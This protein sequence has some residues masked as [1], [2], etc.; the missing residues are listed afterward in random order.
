ME[1]IRQPWCTIDI[2]IPADRICAVFFKCIKRIHC[3][4]LRLT[5]LLTVFILY[6]SKDDNIL[7]RR[8]VKEQCR[9][10]HQRIEPSTGLVYCL[11]NKLSRE[12]FFEKILILK[13][14]MVLCKRHCS[15]IK[16]AVDHFR[17]A[18]HCLTTVRTGKCNGINIWAVKL[19][20]GI[21][22]ITTALSQLCTASDGLLLAAAF[23]FP[24]I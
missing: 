5:H 15:T 22:R 16:P 9:L 8:L 4:S 11:R 17:Y 1:T 18:L 2:E 21:F 14:I 19:Y 23:T 13:W 10:C 7:I 6:M 12:L 20:F 3:I 24:N